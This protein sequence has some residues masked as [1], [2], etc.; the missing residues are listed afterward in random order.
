MQLEP[1]LARA[2]P[3][4]ALGVPAQVQTVPPTVAGREQRHFDPREI[5]ASFVVVV[6]DEPVGANLLAE[7]DAI[8]RELLIRESLIAAY[9][10][11]GKAAAGPALPESMLD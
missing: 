10:E 3:D 4:V 1:L 2:G 11:C 8:A 5:R 9:R 6:V 7:V